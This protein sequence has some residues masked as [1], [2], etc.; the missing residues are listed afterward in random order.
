[1]L[2]FSHQNQRS[3]FG[4]GFYY[5]WKNEFKE[6]KILCYIKPEFGVAYQIRITGGIGFPAPSFFDITIIASYCKSITK[7]VFKIYTFL[8]DRVLSVRKTPINSVFV[9]Q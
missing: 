2:L 7:L 6:I 1:M 3:C 8:Q 9:R 4:R 5:T